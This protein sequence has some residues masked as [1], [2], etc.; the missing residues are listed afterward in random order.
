MNEKFLEF[1]TKSEVPNSIPV[2]DSVGAIRIGNTH[3]IS[4]AGR[5]KFEAEVVFSSYTCKYIAA[6]YGKIGSYVYHI[7]NNKNKSK[8]SRHSICFT[9]LYFKGLIL[10]A[11][12]DIH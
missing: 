8:L 7:I 4:K 12:H 10:D 5:L 3:R 2:F 6:I 1:C 9:S 11:Y